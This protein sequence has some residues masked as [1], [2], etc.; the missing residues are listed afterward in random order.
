MKEGKIDVIQ[1]WVKGSGYKCGSFGASSITNREIAVGDFDGNL[2][3]IDIETGKPTFQVKAHNSVINCIDAI[4]GSGNIGP[5]EIVTG[6][7]DSKLLINH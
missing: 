1:E 5:A 4:G 7:R 6:S 3:I 2:S